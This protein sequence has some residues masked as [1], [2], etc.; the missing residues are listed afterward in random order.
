MKQ[1]TNLIV[2]IDVEKSTAMS[3]AK[4]IKNTSIWEEHWDNRFKRMMKR[5]TPII[6]KYRVGVGLIPK[7]KAKAKELD[8]PLYVE[9]WGNPDF[10]Q[11]DDGFNNL[12]NSFN[13]PYIFE[14]HQEEAVKLAIRHKHSLFQLPTGA[15]KTFICYC[16]VQG[17]MNLGF[18][19]M[20]LFIVPRTDLTTQTIKSWRD[21]GLSCE[22]LEVGG[23]AKG[24]IENP[25]QP[26]IV[27]GT[28]Q[29]LT[30]F[31][32]EY[33]ESF[34]AVICDE[35]HTAGCES[36]QNI[37]WKCVNAKYVCGMSGTIV[38]KDELR[39]N[40]IIQIF[41]EERMKIQTVELI[42]IGFLS[43]MDLNIIICDW[44]NKKIV[45]QMN[46]PEECRFWGSQDII[47]TQMDK[48]ISKICEI[49]VGN[50]FLLCVQVEHVDLLYKAAN[51]RLKNK[52]I[53]KIYGKIKKKDRVNIID[54]FRKTNNNVVCGT[55]ATLST[56]IDAP[57]SDIVFVGTT[58]S[59]YTIPQSIGRVLR[60]NPNKKI[61]NVWDVV[62]YAKG[63]FKCKK[64]NIDYEHGKQRLQLYQEHKYNVK[65]I[66]IQMD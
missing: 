53:H 27:A 50:V 41:G 56:G 39:Y 62:N 28:F 57:M 33:M 25:E 9:L 17:L 22:V 24:V 49:S 23:G 64:E 60:K 30:K 5:P 35:V 7:I 52:N 26:H 65:V 42:D 58:K 46:Y 54:E 29:T 8:I 63:N 10:N 66:N 47:D 20:L 4:L 21:Y 48:I 11:T 13:R 32:K 2:E 36:I 6:V 19:F 55:F 18:C 38:K 1:I 44:D 31:S 37:L 16:I 15:G 34:D 14:P 59:P 43:Q 45:R 61:A 12:M 40:K 3:V 51:E